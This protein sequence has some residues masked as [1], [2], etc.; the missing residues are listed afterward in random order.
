[1]NQSPFVLLVTIHVRPGC[2]EEFLSFA[3][4]TNDAMRHEPTFVNTVLHR[5]A[6]DPTLFMLY[7]T[8]VDREDFFNVQMKRSYREAYEARLPALL[9]Q[10]REMK[11]FE[12]LR[13]DFVFRSGP[14]S[15][16]EK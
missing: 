2:E 13:S 7:E 3:N 15:S 6:E 12:P 5:S 16:P 9:R 4:R 11:V 1:M 10:P 14:P 8:W